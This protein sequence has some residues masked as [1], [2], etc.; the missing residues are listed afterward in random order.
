[1]MICLTARNMFNF[2]SYMNFDVLKISIVKNF[3]Y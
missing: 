2:K 1:M 3:V